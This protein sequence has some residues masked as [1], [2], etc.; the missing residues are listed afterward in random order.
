VGLPQTYSLNELEDRS[1]FDG[2][3]IAYYISLD[4]LPKVGRRGPKTRYSQEFIDRLMFTRRVRDLQDAGKLRAVTLSEIKEVIDELPADELRQASSSRGIPERRIAGL[5]PEPDLDTGDLA[6]V[7]EESATWS[8]GSFSAPTAQIKAPHKAADKAAG[9]ASAS[10]RRRALQS[11]ME[12]VEAVMMESR[13]RDSSELDKL[14]SGMRRAR[15]E[16]RHMH[17][18]TRE[19]MRAEMGELKELVLMLN[20]RLEQLEARD[21]QGEDDDIQDTEG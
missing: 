6:G 5:F 15:D 12:S 10:Q 13:R 18:Q 3:T 20:R 14:T 11:Q 8:V 1:G 4:L 2:R 19:E 9:M 16:L 17:E 21:K 7:A